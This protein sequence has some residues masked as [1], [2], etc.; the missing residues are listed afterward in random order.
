MKDN[1]RIYAAAVRGRD[2]FCIAVIDSFDPDDPYS[3]ILSH[4][5]ALTQPW[6][7][8][9]VSRVVNAITVHGLN[10]VALSNEGDVYTLLADRTLNDKIPGAG[11]F[12]PDAKGLGS[13]TAI[14]C[15]GGLLHVVGGSGQIYRRDAAGAWTSLA[16]PG[17]GVTSAYSLLTLRVVAGTGSELIYVAGF[18]TPASRTLTQAEHELDRHPDP[19]ALARSGLQGPPTAV[20]CLCPRCDAT[21]FLV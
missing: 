12:S 20:I 4:D 14:A 1:Q 10:Y 18:A 7:R 6:G 9:D 17:L 13:T 19:A 16:G 11:T 21:G 15:I 2:N 8:V 5:G 3:F